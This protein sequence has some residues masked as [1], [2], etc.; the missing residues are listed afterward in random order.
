MKKI[1]TLHEKD[2]Y[3]K[4]QSDENI[5]TGII[6][7]CLEEVGCVVSILDEVG[8]IDDYRP[9][10][11]KHCISYCYTARILGGKGNPKYTK[12]YLREV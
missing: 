4:K 12:I 5:Q 7:E 8:C 1:T 3:P 6:R 11:K 2:I 9:R 10:D